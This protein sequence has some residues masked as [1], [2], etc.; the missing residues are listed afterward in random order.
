[1]IGRYKDRAP[2]RSPGPDAYN[3]F[4]SVS[5]VKRTYPSFI[6]GHGPKTERD[7]TTRKIVPG[8][9]AYTYKDL[10]QTGVSFSH[11]K[12]LNFKTNETPGPGAYRVPVKFADVPKYLIPGKDDQLKFI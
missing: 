12:R 9:G 10:Y 5:V 7:L 1:M 3:G 11:A 2:E 8:P 6:F 4:Q